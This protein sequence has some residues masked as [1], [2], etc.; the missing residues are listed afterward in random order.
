MPLSADWISFLSSTGM[1][2]SRSTVSS[3]FPNS[4]SM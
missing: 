3:T 4:S 1:T 2:Y